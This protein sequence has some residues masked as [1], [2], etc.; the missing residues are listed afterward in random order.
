MEELRSGQRRGIWNEH[1]VAKSK[2]VQQ[3]QSVSLRAEVTYWTLLGQASAGT[4]PAQEKQG[5][6]PSCQQQYRL[7]AAEASRVCWKCLQ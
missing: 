5:Q 2:E 3:G 6:Q 1:N 4:R 7:A